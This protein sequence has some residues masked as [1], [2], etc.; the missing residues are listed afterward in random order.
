[1]PVE[2]QIKE[3][4][5]LILVSSLDTLHLYLVKD[6]GRAAMLL[7]GDDPV[8]LARALATYIGNLKGLV[9]AGAEPL[10]NI[11]GS[12]SKGT[13]RLLL[14]PRRKHRPDAFFEQGDARIV[15]S[16]AVMEMAGI[17]VTPIE[18]DFERLDAAAV[19]GIYD[20]VSLD[21]KT[22]ERASAQ[23]IHNQGP[24]SKSR[25]PACG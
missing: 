15:V 17:L 2:Q 24:L 8:A 10:L 13:W 25:V 18:R 21:A 23:L 20:E 22:F 7:Q 16:P 3:A 11:A 5:R 9:R 19:E 12:Y 14:F 6:L 4:K 1:M